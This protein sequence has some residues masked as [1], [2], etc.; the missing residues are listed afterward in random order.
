MPAQTLYWC[1]VRETTGSEAF[2]QTYWTRASQIGSA[3]GQIV[4]A[5]RLNGLQNP[6]PTAIDPCE[7]GDPAG[8]VEPGP[9]AQTFWT[10]VRIYFPPEPCFTAPDGVIAARAQG[11]NDR[12]DIHSGFTLAKDARGL[13]TIEINVD[14]SML[15]PLYERLIN[16][17]PSY[18]V[19]WYLM[20]AH[21]DNSADQF[22]VNP[23]LDNPGGILEH[24]RGH[25]ADSLRNGHVTLTAFCKEG[26]H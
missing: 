22:L 6:V 11:G 23:S 2:F 15:L 5:A 12:S 14:R 3:I 10:R 24:L 7:L 4:A 8:G 16:V 9:D 19:F 13:T 21:W 1:L 25:E 26:G 17:R 20:H 18:Q